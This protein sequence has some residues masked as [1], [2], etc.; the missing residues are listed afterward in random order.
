MASGQISAVGSL[1]L[2]WSA[3]GGA[4]PT[5]GV[6]PA[7][8]AVV[9]SASA[10][11]MDPPVLPALVF[12]AH[13]FPGGPVL[14]LVMPGPETESSRFPPRRS[15]FRTG[16]VC[17]NQHLATNAERG[18][19]GPSGPAVFFTRNARRAAGIERGLVR[20]ISGNR[21]FEWPSPDS[22]FHLDDHG[23]RVAVLLDRR[24]AGW[25]PA[26][27]WQPACRR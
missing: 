16:R 6:I 20:R 4:S 2:G 10:T 21:L 23:G 1:P 14:L 9:S 8:L 24:G 27:G 11:R 17:G 18:G 7:Q 15:C 12:R 5:R 25:H 26:A 3:F 19:L 22:D 13:P